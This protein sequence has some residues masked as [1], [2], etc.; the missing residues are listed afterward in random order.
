LRY[1]E[2]IAARKPRRDNPEERIHRAVVDHLRTRAKTGVVWWHTPNGGKRGIAEARRFKALGVRPG[3]SDLLAFFNGELF[4]L[5]LKAPNGRPS[6]SQFTFISDMQ[7]QGAYACIA[8]GL[9]EAI[10]VLEAWGLL[11]GK[12]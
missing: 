10:A 9:N 1:Q 5:E 2:A 12:V 11:R 6:E 7:K 3:V 4:C 8:E